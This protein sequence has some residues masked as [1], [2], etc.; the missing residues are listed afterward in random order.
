MSYKRTKNRIPIQHIPDESESCSVVWMSACGFD[1]SIM[2][3][4]PR[5][6]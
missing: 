6:V 3:V 4:P 2:R 1:A 5:A